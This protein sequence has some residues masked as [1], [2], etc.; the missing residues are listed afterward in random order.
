[1][2]P[3]YIFAAILGGGL[4][5]IGML[6]GDGG[7][8][9]DADIDMGGKASTWTHAFSFQT[10]AYFLAAFGL[11]G[12]ALTLVGAA[13]VPTLLVSVA[14]GLTVGTLV[15]VLFRWL[16]RSQSGFA[17]SSDDYIGGVGRAEIRI[18]VGGQG[19]I[20]LVHRGQ[21]FTL[22]AVSAAEEIDRNEHV[23]VLDVVDGVALVDRA[24]KELTL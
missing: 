14:M 17:E 12:S 23:I 11:V 1:M 13:T 7:D 2:L 9:V 4:L 6:G 19:R 22:P 20:A 21:S 5:L 3:I 24:P 10:A 18:P 16:K 8:G 15:G